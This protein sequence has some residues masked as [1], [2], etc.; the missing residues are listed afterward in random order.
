MNVDAWPKALEEA[1]KDPTQYFY[2]TQCSTQRK[3]FTYGRFVVD[4]RPDKT[5][6]HRVRLTVGGNLI[7]YPGDVSAHSADLT[8]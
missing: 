4:I 5:E 1:L 7:Q 8:T 3:K 6:T 2:P